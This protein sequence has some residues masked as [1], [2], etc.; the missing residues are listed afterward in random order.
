MEFTALYSA[1]H[2][3]LNTFPPLLLADAQRLFDQHTG[4]EPRV[5]LME[6]QRRARIAIKEPDRNLLAPFQSL[7]HRAVEVRRIVAVLLQF[8]YP[9][10]ELV[11]G[12]HLGEGHAGA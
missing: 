8:V 3:L 4:L 1:L 6:A 7:V 10:A 11:V 2:E 9:F 5:L 12:L